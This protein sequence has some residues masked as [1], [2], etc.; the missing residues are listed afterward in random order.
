[1]EKF[2]TVEGQL[3]VKTNELKQFKLDVVEN[4]NQKNQAVQ[5]MNDYMNQ[6]NTLK[7][8]KE[9]LI[10]KLTDLEDNYD[11]KEQEFFTMKKEKNNMFVK[12]KSEEDVFRQKA[13]ALKREN[14]HQ[15]MINEDTHAKLL[16][17]E[18]AYIQVSKKLKNELAEAK[19]LR[20]EFIKYSMMKIWMRSS[21]E[22]QN[23]NLEERQR[24]MKE[25]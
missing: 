3:K 11:L 20:K 23:R 14:N 6:V 16:R 5:Q 22:T 7:K 8:T 24:K 1:M 2:K 4:E 21:R 10:A 15:R 25:Q 17:F 13:R 12:L 9:Q 19:F 18:E